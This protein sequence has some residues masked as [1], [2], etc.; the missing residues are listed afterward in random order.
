MATQYRA[1]YN[2][3]GL[4]H[5]TRWHATSAAAWECVRRV[6][7]R[8]GVDLGHEPGRVAGDLHSAGRI[9][10]VRGRGMAYLETRT[11][12]TRQVYYI[13]SGE[14]ERG[15]WSGPHCTTLLG[16]RRYAARE[17]CHG[18]RWA[19]VWELMPETSE[20]IAHIRDVDT[21]DRR[22]VPQVD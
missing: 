13:L 18:D 21:G 3:Y 15:T 9:E 10:G 8:A 5:T 17:R 4:Q 12:P 16:A 14:G 2:G 6:A 22:D 7:R 1:Q 11:A 20:T 19:R